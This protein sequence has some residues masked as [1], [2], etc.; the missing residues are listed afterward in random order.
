MGGVTLHL[1]HPG[2]DRPELDR[3]GRDPAA[4][5][6]VLAGGRP[7]G[8]AAG[9]AADGPAGHRQDDAGDG[10]SPAAEA[11]ALHQPVHGRHAARGPGRHAGA[12]RERE[13]RLPRLAAGLGDDRGGRV[14]ARR[15]KPDER[16]VVG[17]PGPAARPSP[18]R[19]EHRGRHHDPR[20]SGFPRLR[21]DERGRVDLRGARLHPLAAAADPDSGLPQPRRRD[22]DPQVPPAVRRGLRCWP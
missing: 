22:G 20:S 11:A 1:E 18:L 12:G 13:D 19:R 6:G 5:S 8:P 4:A 17:Q 2:H 14:R 21:D 3:P 15:G 9:A 7:A 10:G 16:E